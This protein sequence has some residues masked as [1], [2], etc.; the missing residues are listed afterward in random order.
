[1][2]MKLMKLLPPLHPDR[3]SSQ[4]QIHPPPSYGVALRR[5][6]RRL[7]ARPRDFAL[8][9]W[10]PLLA[11]LVLGVLVSELPPSELRVVVVDDD[12]SAVSR[13]LLRR[14]DAGPE[15]RVIQVP[16]TTQAAAEVSAGRAQ[17]ALHVP[18]GFG[19]QLSAPLPALAA[20]AHGGA[21]EIAESA[22]AD[23]RRL[24]IRFAPQS[25]ADDAR[26]LQHVHAVLDHLALDGDALASAAIVL[27][28]QTSSRA[29]ALAGTS[30]TASPTAL[31]AANLRRPRGE[32]P[33]AAS[34]QPGGLAL[35]IDAPALQARADALVTGSAMLL[36]LLH[37]LAAM[38]AASVVGREFKERS[39]YQ[40]LAASG[41][42]WRVALAAKLTLPAALAGGQALLGLLLWQMLAPAPL[43]GSLWM[44]VAA[45]LMSQLAGLSIGL[46]F[47]GLLPSLRSTLALLGLLAPL[48]LV[49]LQHAAAGSPWW[50]ELLPLVHALRLVDRAWWLPST[51]GVDWSALRELAVLALQVAG[52][53]ALGGWLL[54]RR[55]FLPGMM[56]Q[57]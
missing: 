33:A 29:P 19:A 32:L 2:A 31:A 25:R 53:T 55:A 1:M 9:T 14:L 8:A 49:M 5:E 18:L 22:D 27:P 21:A 44:V 46:L 17:A 38:L 10:L 35:H 47:C 23:A 54:S 34:P 41:R 40:W 48:A 57:A 6:W 52:V 3:R 12:A 11:M 16:T 7:L 37:L 51:L 45:L 50:S 28:G 39:A 20:P 30:A 15:L 24:D 43:Q 13:L 26:V 56:R 36:M 4:E 42:R